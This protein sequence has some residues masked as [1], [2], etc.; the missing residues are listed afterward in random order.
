MSTP[1]AP[2]IYTKTGDN[3]ETGLVGGQRVSKDDPRI[4]A[5]GTVDELNSVIG[6][7]RAV[8]KTC[9]AMQSEDPLWNTIQHR[10]FDLGSQ[11]ATLPE[12]RTSTMPKVTDADVTALEA[13]MDDANASLAPLRNFIIPGGS[14][15]NAA[16]HMA[17]TVARRAERLVVRL[18]RTGG[19]EALDVQYLNR[20]SDAFFIWARQS[21]TA[22][23]HA[24]VAWQPALGA[25]GPNPDEGSR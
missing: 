20:L 10:L 13:A 5:Y 19:C 14:T 24:E 23:G 7:V 1:R 17:R 3:G 15:L 8:A 16:L 9:N 11:L 2:R 12:D 4:E 6:W 22:L 25:A 21:A 18:H